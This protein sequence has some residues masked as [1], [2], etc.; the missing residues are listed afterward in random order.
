MAKAFVEP[1]FPAQR[2]KRPVEN[3]VFRH[4]LN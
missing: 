2:T 4:E 3:S 1:F